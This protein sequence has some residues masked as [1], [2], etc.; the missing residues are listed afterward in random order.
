M[1][2]MKAMLMIMMRMKKMKMRLPMVDKDDDYDD[3][4]GDDDHDEFY[5]RC[6]LQIYILNLGGQ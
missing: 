5:H 3:C 2:M 4:A 6:K 1:I